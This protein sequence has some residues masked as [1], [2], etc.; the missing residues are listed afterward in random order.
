MRRFTLR[1]ASLYIIAIFT[2]WSYCKSC[3]LNCSRV[4]E[5]W[6]EKLYFWCSRYFFFDFALICYDLIALLIKVVNYSVRAHQV[7]SRQKENTN[8]F[9]VQIKLCFF[10]HLKFSKKFWLNR[11]F[12]RNI[13]TSKPDS[14]L[15]SSFISFHGFML[16]CIRAFESRCCCQK[17]KQWVSEHT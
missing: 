1:F 12:I 4:R 16:M 15:F 17:V 14:Y 11:L 13:I 10:F 9:L 5:T 6:L 3:K 7:G 8:Q 2:S